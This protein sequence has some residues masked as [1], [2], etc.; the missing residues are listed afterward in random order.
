MRQTT[1]TQPKTPNPNQIMA[2]GLTRST[3]RSE[4]LACEGS[5]LEDIVGLRP[6]GRCAYVPQP[7]FGMVEV[8]RA[9]G[10][11]REVHG[12]S[13]IQVIT[14]IQYLICSWCSYRQA[15]N[16]LTPG[17]LEEAARPPHH[18]GRRFWGGRGREGRRKAASR[19]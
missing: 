18:P 11:G 13:F 2:S 3:A 10:E 5:W 12:Q 4:G 14:H 1:P 17:G 19:V 15:T 6:L 7:A 16:Q 9:G 8:S